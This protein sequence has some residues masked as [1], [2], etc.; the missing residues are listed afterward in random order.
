MRDTCLDTQTTSDPEL[1]RVANESVQI[2]TYYQ[3]FRENWLLPIS[4]AQSDLFT[5]LEMTCDFF[6]TKCEVKMCL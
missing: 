2:H 1:G 4:E 3:T 6:L 5:F